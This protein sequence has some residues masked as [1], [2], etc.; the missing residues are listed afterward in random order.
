MSRRYGSPHRSCGK[1]DNVCFQPRVRQRPCSNQQRGNGRLSISLCDI[2]ARS[3]SSFILFPIFLQGSAAQEPI[4]HS[5][6]SMLDSSTHLLKTARSLVLNPKDPPTWSVLA[7]HS[8]TVSDSIKSLIT[9][10][11]SVI[12][13]H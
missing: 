13:R 6:C 4:L 11:R 8:R 7:G 12:Y 1:L 5:A 9:A 10:I 2:H 3:H